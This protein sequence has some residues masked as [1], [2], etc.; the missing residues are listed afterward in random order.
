MGLFEDLFSSSKNTT[1]NAS[2]SSSSSPWAASMPLISSLLGSY[3]S[4]GT[5]VTGDQ[6]GALAKLQAALSNAPNFGDAAASAVGNLF[7]KGDSSPQVGM[8]NDAYSTLKTNLGSTASGA[9]LNPYDTPG[10]SDAM[11]TA[12]DDATKSVKGVYAGSGRSP[13]GAGSFAGSLGRGI[14]QGISPTIASQFNQ[15]Y[16]NMI[17]ANNSLLTG[18]NNTASSINNL[19]SGDIAATSAA[20]GGAAGVPGLYGSPAMAQ[21]GAANMAYSQPYQ[22]LAQ[23]LQPSVA[24]AG[25]GSTSNGTQSGTGTQT[26]TPSLMSGIGT[27][28]GMLGTGL[29]MAPSLGTAA[30]SLLAMFS[31]E[32][33]KTDIAPVGKL[34][35]G[36]NVYSYRYKGD[37]TPR[38][39]LM[40]QEVRKHRPEAVVKHPSGFLMVDYDAATK[41][42]RVGALAA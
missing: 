40:A 27:G 19:R 3:G 29:Q 10:F 38:I 17:G 5:G 36:Q 2:T 28:L 33:L 24:L 13:S 37:A 14:T 1:Q 16:G 39:G 26:S 9:N 21:Y 31:D 12:I 35:D 30:S 18:A 4:L 15:N 8:L 42:A 25:L 20:L 6:G 23:L 32:R 22:N 34:N 11:R 7:S 41:G